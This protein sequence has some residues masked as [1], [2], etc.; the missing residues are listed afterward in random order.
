MDQAGIARG[1]SLGRVARPVLGIGRT[2][3]AKQ[4]H[5]IMGSGS[6]VDPGRGNAHTVPV[7]HVTDTVE[8]MGPV[9]P[10][11]DRTAGHM[12]AGN[13]LLSAG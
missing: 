11:R 8:P 4:S 1:S 5:K 6:E 9:S 3:D 7:Q 10:D 12:P 2:V 13:C